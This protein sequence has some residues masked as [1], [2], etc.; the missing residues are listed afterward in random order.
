MTREGEYSGLK[1]YLLNKRILTDSG[2]D[3]RNLNT[4]YVRIKTP[5]RAE[6]LLATGMIARV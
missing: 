1:E 6:D 3:W 4:S 5:A 2:G